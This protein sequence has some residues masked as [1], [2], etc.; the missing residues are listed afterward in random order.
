VQHHQ[1]LL[2]L[3]L[4]RHKPHAA[5]LHRLAARLRIGRVVLV[6]LDVGPHVLRRHQPD[7]VAEPGQLPGPVM[8]GAA[9]P[10]LVADG[11]M[12][13]IGRSGSNEPS[14]DGGTS[15]RCASGFEKRTLSNQLVTMTCEHVVA[16]GMAA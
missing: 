1:G 5:P 15:R 4:R 14:S 11:P 9:R 12:V 16:G 7:G 10:V 6:G 3:A 2:I 8:G 13:T